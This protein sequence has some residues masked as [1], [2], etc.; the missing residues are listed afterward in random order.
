[1][2]DHRPLFRKESEQARSAAWLGRV[3][4]IRPV[5]FTFI[6]ICALSFSIALGSFFVAGEYTR[7]ARVTGVLAPIEGVAK[8]IAQQ[9]GI[10]EAVHVREGD[11]VQKD[12]ALMI[13]GDGRASRAK[14]DVGRAITSR[15]A[16]RRDALVLQL[17][18]AATAMRSEQAA[19]A[20]RRAG[21]QRE[22]EQIDAEMASQAKRMTIAANGVDRARRLEDIGFLSPAALDRERDAALDQEAR[23]EQLRRT[24]LALTRELAAVEF[25]A[26]TA[27]ARA[28]SQAAALDMQRASLDQERIERDLQYHAAIV[29]PAAGVIA[30]VL[31]EPGQM[32]TPGTPLATIIPQNATLEGHLY[33]PSRSIG[34]VHAGQEVLLRYLAYPHQKFGMHKASVTAVSRN[35]LLPNELGFTPIDGTREPVYRI[36]VALEGQAIRA[37]GR[38]EP[39]QPGM[40]IEADILLDRRRLV[41]WVFE[42]LLSLAGRT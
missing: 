21:F 36:K 42:P 35:P 7:K 12:A 39:L 15:V 2:A 31:V 8:I 19:F 37:Y 34:F 30:T 18:L 26:D 5:S 3:V 23:L 13:L 32:V 14:E 27:R 9:S 24:R 6:T 28:S 1:M 40:Q 22:I 11:R 10:V 16:E 33:S 4:L 38:L 25:D 41:E 17:Q 20:Q 29:A